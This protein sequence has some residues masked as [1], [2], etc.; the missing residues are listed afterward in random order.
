M[1]MRKLVVIS[2]AMAGPFIQDSAATTRYVNVSNAAPAAPFTN[3]S[4]AATH[5]QAAIDAAASGD[6]VLVAPGIY[7][8]EHSAVTIP[9]GKTLT[10]RSTQSRAAIIDAQGHSSCMLVQSANS[11]V[12]GFILRNGSYVGHGGGG[13]NVGTNCLV[14]DCLVTGNEATSGGGI[15]A[16]AGARV[17]DCLVLSNRANSGGGVLVMGGAL[18]QGGVVAS[19]TAP[20]GGGIEIYEAGT[21]ADCLIEGNTASSMGGGLVFYSGTTGLVRNCVIRNNTVTNE[22]GEGGGIHIQYAGT[23]SNCWISGNSVTGTNGNGGGVFMSNQGGSVSGRLVNVVIHG[24][25][26]GGRG[27]G[28][29]SV[30]PNGTLASVINCTIVS[31]AAGVE[32]GGVQPHTTR[33]VNDIIYFN[34]A[35]TN[36]NLTPDGA[37]SIVSNCCTTSTN[38]PWPSITNA[39]AFV[40]A[41]AGDFRL[42]TASFCIDAGTTNGAPRTDIEGNPRPRIGKPGMMSTNS[43]MGAYEYGFHFNSIQAVSSNALRLQWDVQDVGRYRVDVATNAAAD[44]LH[45]TWNSVTTYTQ[46]TIIGLGQYAVYNTTVTNPTPPMP[47]HAIFRLNVDRATAGKQ[48]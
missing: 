11:T 41:A 48:R 35:P 16:S 9:A 31:N 2:V 30:G 21:V 36:A 37:D 40:D 24:N 42:A 19:N 3:W 26:A 15:H 28:V 5:I 25:W 13:V 32:G 4:M 43:D 29:Y 6:E 44:P 34:T 39:P 38:Y 20:Q 17:E 47:G 10:L 8:L 22:S 46:A 18:V 23:V 27:G 12:D 1:S 7:Y 14:R 45:P 33:M